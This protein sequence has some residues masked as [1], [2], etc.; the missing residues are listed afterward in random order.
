[1]SVVI[2]TYDSAAWIARAIGALRKTTRCPVEVIVVDN[3]SHDGSV[4]AAK[5]AG[6]DR[7]VEL[8]GNVGFGRACNRGATESSGELLLFLNPDTGVLPGAIDRGVAF[9]RDHPGVGIVGGRA[10][11]ED[12]TSNRFCCFRRP[13]LLSAAFIASGLASVFRRSSTFNCEEMAGWDRSDDRIVDFVSG[14][15]LLIPRPLF[16]ALGG[17]DEQFFMYSEDADL[18]RRVSELG[19]ATVHV[20]SVELVHE[21]GESD[22][23]RS[24]KIVKVWQA[25]AQYY[26]KYWSA[27]QAR[28]GVRLLDAGALTR[29][30]AHTLMGDRERRAR[31]STIWGARERWHVRPARGTTDAARGF[32]CNACG[33]TG[34]G[35]VR[36]GDALDDSATRTCPSCGADDH[37]RTLIA[38]S[39]THAAYEGRCNVRRIGWRGES[40]DRESTDSDRVVE[41]ALVHRDPRSGPPVAVGPLLD[42]L[43]PGGVAVFSGPRAIEASQRAA[44]V[45]DGFSIADFDPLAEFPVT[46]LRRF[47]LSTRPLVIVTRPS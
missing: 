46:T 29:V 28:W 20:A 26:A 44:L 22:N 7:L 13:S 42:S 27:R 41:T 12:G 25:R 39:A 11:H 6:A 37:E 15:F 31:W 14:S 45:R 38:W 8:A 33:W 16:Q 35:F 2:V 10:F 5:A 1:V 18:C 32:T 4:A 43:A 47:G 34:S 30:L 21:G 19:L 9:L 17:F 3:D 23:V 40:H 36:G 24:E